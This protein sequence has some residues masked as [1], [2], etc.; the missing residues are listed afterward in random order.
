[1]ITFHHALFSRS[2]AKFQSSLEA[3]GFINQGVTGDRKEQKGEEARGRALKHCVLG[4]GRWS[5]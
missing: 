4:V 5:I 1:M 3:L 2:F